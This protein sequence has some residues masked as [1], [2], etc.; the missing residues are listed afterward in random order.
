MSAMESKAPTSNAT[1]CA[2]IPW[3]FP[4]AAAMRWNTEMLRALMK[5]LRRF[6][7]QCSFMAAPVVVIAV[8]MPVMAVG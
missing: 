2:G 5:S 3:I 1:S 8:H 6:L 4:S 7:D